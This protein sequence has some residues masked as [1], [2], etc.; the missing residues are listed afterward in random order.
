MIIVI[1]EYL[2][3]YHLY[4]QPVSI[5]DDIHQMGAMTDALLEELVRI[6]PF[7]SRIGS[8][9][10][11]RSMWCC[12]KPHSV[13]HFGNNVE[14]VGHST[15]ISTQVTEST[16]KPVKAKGHLTNKKPDQS[17]LQH[18]DASSCTWF[19]RRSNVSRAGFSRRGVDSTQKG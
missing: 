2:H 18:D 14:Q 9:D 10:K 6:F 3:L 5:T 12:E 19:C 7:S 11:T 1:N 13:T 4:R 17:W 15:K 8:S 16:H